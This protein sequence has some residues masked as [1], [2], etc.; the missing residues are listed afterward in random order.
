MPPAAVAPVVAGASQ[1]QPQCRVVVVAVGHLQARLPVAAVVVV[2]RQQVHPLSRVRLLPQPWRQNV[3]RA[4]LW[5]YEQ[6]KC[7]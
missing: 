4:T 3:V 1:P 6:V 2:P 5:G 7:L